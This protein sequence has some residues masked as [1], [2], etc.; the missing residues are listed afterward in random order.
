MEVII[1]RKGRQEGFDERKL[2][3]SCYS[4][5]T[6]THHGKEESEQICAQV[7]D[8]VKLFLV[9]KKEVDSDELFRETVREL[10]KVSREAAFMYETH[11]DIS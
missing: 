5:C 8:A 3:A 4:A 6:T 11:R 9:D 2:Y 1:K 7:T 10:E